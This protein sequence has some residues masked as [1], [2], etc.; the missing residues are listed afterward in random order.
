LPGFTGL[1]TRRVMRSTDPNTIPFDIRIERRKYQ[2]T[3]ERSKVARDMK[4]REGKE[5]TPTKVESP[6][7][8]SLV[9][10]P[11]LPVKYLKKICDK[12]KN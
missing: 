11:S 8:C 4:I 7:I 6:L 5:K 1:V 12:E 2:E 9:T 10:T 3:E